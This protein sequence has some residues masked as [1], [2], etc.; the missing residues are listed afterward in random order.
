MS[1]HQTELASI[2]HL[3]TGAQLI[4]ERGGKLAYL[5]TFTFQAGGVSITQNLLFVP[6]PLANYN[7]SRLY[8]ERPIAGRGRNWSTR[9]IVGRL[10]HTPSYKVDSSCGWRDQ[11]LQHLQAVA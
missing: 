11:I 8:Y 2:R 9:H 1:I 6:Q 7:S 3:C 4:D 10:W 5:P